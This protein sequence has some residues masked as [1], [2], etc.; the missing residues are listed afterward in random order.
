[1]IEFGG[2]VMSGFSDLSVSRAGDWVS[3]S[4]EIVIVGWIGGFCDHTLDD[5]DGD[6]EVYIGT[7]LQLCCVVLC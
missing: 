7:R 5:D 2:E 3:G 6:V 1:M 4:I